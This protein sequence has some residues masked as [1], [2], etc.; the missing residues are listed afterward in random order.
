MAYLETLVA[1][2]P[3]WV[4]DTGLENMKWKDLIN[5]IKA[6]RR[7]YNNGKKRKDFDLGVDLSRTICDSYLEFEK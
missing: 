6:I 2:N 1:E 3:T 7:R 4:R 5:V